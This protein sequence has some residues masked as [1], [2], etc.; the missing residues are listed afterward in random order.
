MSERV[1]I[2]V[3]AVPT[4]AHVSDTTDAIVKVLETAAATRTS[5][6]LALAALNVLYSAA[7]AGHIAM[8]NCAVELGDKNIHASN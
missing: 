8:S 1:G 6:T 2:A 3:S 7:Q 5:D 4:A